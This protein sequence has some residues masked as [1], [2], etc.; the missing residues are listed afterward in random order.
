MIFNFLAFM[1]RESETYLFDQVF[2][3][4][5]IH[6]FACTVDNLRFGVGYQFRGKSLDAYT[7]DPAFQLLSERLLAQSTFCYFSMPIDPG[8]QAVLRAWWLKNN[9]KLSIANDYDRFVHEAVHLLVG[10]AKRMELVH[11]YSC[12]Y[13]SA[14]WMDYFVSIFVE[15]LKSSEGRLSKLTKS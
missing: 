3:E 14:D 8:T 9:P 6:S 15:R 12:W 5:R 13:P 7:K 4:K 11:N 1:V 10:G 2:G